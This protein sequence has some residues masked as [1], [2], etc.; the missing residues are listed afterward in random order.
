MG[1]RRNEPAALATEPPRFI[2]SRQSIGS[3]NP[4]ARGRAK[5]KSTIKM[6]G[7]AFAAST[8]LATAAEAQR[9]GSYGGGGP[10]T[11]TPQP[12]GGEQQKQ[13]K[14]PKGSATV[15]IGNQK[16]KI[17]A[18]FAKAY[19]ELVAAVDG[20]DTANIPAKFAAAHAAAQTGDEHFLASQAQLKAGIAAGI[21]LRWRPPLRG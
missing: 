13:E 16:I 15:M 6:L 20:N 7:I 14:A 4:V 21:T 10:P 2:G 8:A 3:A 9:E 18:A 5:V 12:R 17:S 19:Q 11:T 1:F